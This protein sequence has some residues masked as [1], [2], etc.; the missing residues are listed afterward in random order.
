ME[1]RWVEGVGERGRTQFRDYANSVRE[2]GLQYKKKR[3]V[4]DELM[5]ERDT[6]RLTMERLAKKFGMLRERIVSRF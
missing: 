4:L 2:R 5:A 1:R 3:R 6:V